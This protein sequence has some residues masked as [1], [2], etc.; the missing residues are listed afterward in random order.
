MLAAALPVIAA[1]LSVPLLG[2]GD[3]AIIGRSAGTAELAA[4]ALATTLFNLLFWSFGFLRMGV[5]GQVARAAGG[6]APA[7]AALAVWRALLLAVVVGILLTLLGQWLAAPALALLGAAEATEAPA[8]AYAELRLWGAPATLALYVCT[9]AMIGAGHTRALMV[10]QIGLNGLNLA[11]NWLLVYGYG[12][13]LAGV[14]IGT[15]VAEVVAV[16]A[17]YSWLA[18][19]LPM[20]RTWCDPALWRRSQW[21]ALGRLNGHLWLRTVALLLGF[22]L[23]IRASSG[24]G[25]A[26]LAA[27]HLLLGLIS[28]SAFFLDGFAFVAESRVGRA[29]GSGDTNAL[30]RAVRHSSELALIVAA[31]LALA[32]A[33]LGSWGVALLSDLPAVRAAAAPLLNWAALYVLLSVLAFQLDGIYVGADLS[34]AMRDSVLLALA[35]FGGA[36]LLLVPRWGAH[37]L[38]VA[39]CVFVLARGLFSLCYWR[40]LQAALRRP[41]AA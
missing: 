7:E 35:S 29:V 10:L 26:V 19:A 6:E 20:G 12:L 31:L 9:G 3:T 2:L 39:F 36:L 41:A 5:S 1:N 4:L 33:G 16:A 30:T 27:N 21:R 32:V 13:G 34:R 17:G 40:H 8:Q 11:L 38:W 18:K 24:F 37:G 22:A 25:P 14:A 23:F 15:C 28:F